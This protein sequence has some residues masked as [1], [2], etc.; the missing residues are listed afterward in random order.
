MVFLIVYFILANFLNMFLLVAIS[1]TFP[2]NT[3]LGVDKFEEDVDNIKTYSKI[4]RL[5]IIYVFYMFLFRCFIQICKAINK[6]TC[7]KSKG[8]EIY[9]VLFYLIYIFGLPVAIVY[10]IMWCCYYVI[11]IYKHSDK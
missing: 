8:G 7:V 9:L 4:K 11:Q 6:N 5:I 3:V 1:D 2:D 10:S